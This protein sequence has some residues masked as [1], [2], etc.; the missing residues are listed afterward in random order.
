MWNKDEVQGK[1]DRAKGRAKEAA[2]DL[3]DNEQL[4]EE[5]AADEAAGNVQETF[6][7]GRRKVGEALKDL[8]DSIKK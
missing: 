6:G 2:G 4:R 5:G 8:G 3:S 7:K 1:V